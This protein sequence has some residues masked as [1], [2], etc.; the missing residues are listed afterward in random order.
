MTNLPDLNYDVVIVG[1]GIAG[2]LMALRLGQSPNVKRI[3]VLEAGESV[4]PNINEE[5]EQF[6][7]ATAKVPESA[8]KPELLLNP[9]DPKSPLRDPATVPAGRPTVLSLAGAET[10]RDPKQSYLIQTGVVPFG[11]TYE[12]T[13]GG[14]SL[15][16][17]GT[18]L[19]FLPND[20]DL[21]VSHRQDWPKWPTDINYQSLEEWYC[22]AEHEIGVSANVKDQRYAGVEFGL[23]PEFKGYT[24]PMP[25]IPP[26]LTDNFVAGAIDGMSIEGTPIKVRGTPAARNSQPFKNRRVCAGNTN[27]IPI[28]PIQAKYD[29]TITLHD[30]QATGKVDFLYRTVAYNIAL[31]ERGRV[32]HIDYKQY[33]PDGSLGLTGKA[34]GKVFIIA[35]NAIETPRLLLMSNTQLSKGVA[36]KSGQV[37]RNLMDHPFYVI[38][39][40]LPQATYPYRGPLSTSGIED[41]RDGDFRK[42]HAAFRVELG[43]DGWNFAIGGDP[44]ITTVD[45]V[46]GLNA[47]RLNPT[48]LTVFGN[49]LVQRLRDVLTRQ[50]RLGFLI[51]QE[52][53]ERN[54]VTLSA[55]FK[56]GLGLPRPEVYYSLSDYT[57]RG[58]AKAKEAGEAI[59]A[60]LN[61]KEFTSFD[62]SDPS[63]VELPPNSFGRQ[64]HI[65]IMGAGHIIG[66]HR[67][68]DD[69]SASVV[70]ANQRS[71]DHENLYLI[72]SGSFPTS[73]TANPTLTLAALTLRTADWIAK[74]DLKT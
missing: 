65:R 24:Y 34:D 55:D 44:N 2:A 41:L 50:L 63:V 36:N 30:A 16:W 6:Y 39:G 12:R 60:R 70:N 53:D 1:S 9:S 40:L 15:H 72:G 38:W 19:R 14:T 42:E 23:S 35:A 26:S 67:M 5:M 21:K 49:D 47:S 33:N 64:E 46:N 37:G 7:K 61:V 71:H 56:D 22:R 54:R 48:N 29:P 62:E 45:F 59:F 74:H 18:S 69:P 8:Y 31:D 57:L 25:G 4:P 73:A 66:T 58:L 68:G 43:N 52:P 32:S 20:F 51:E 27:C 11:S 10:W 3:L 17:L 13:A 28:C